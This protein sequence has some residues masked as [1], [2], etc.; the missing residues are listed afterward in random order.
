[1][2]NTSDSP[3]NKNPRRNK[4]RANIA[5]KVSATDCTLILRSLIESSSD[6]FFVKDRALRT[7]LCNSN[8]ASALDKKPED[9]YGK[10]DVENG[11]SPEQVK[12]NPEKGIK[13]WETDD[14]DALG[15][16]TVRAAQEPVSSEGQMRYFDT[17]KTPLR[18]EEGT[19]IG[20]LGIGRDVTDRVLA[21]VEL[22]KSEQRY[23]SL[24]T[25]MIDGYAYGR[26]IF[27]NG[28]PRDFVY[29]DVNRAFEEHTG[30]KDVIGKRMTEVIPGIRESQPE[31][32]RT[33]GNVAVNGGTDNFEIFLDTLGVWLSV[34]VYG[35]EKHYFTAV[36]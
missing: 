7:V 22:K 18:D 31:L 33:C 1:V 12:G 26:M 28:E 27:E 20:V 34:T 17:V 9:M 14:R 2:K 32:F 11:W 24:F 21:D 10:T 8:L 25:N 19:I 29:L 3:G 5:K 36:L 6:T 13:G 30:L 16:K 23:H 15:G 35:T 4:A